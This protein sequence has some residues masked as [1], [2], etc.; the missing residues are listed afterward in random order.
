MS[1]FKVTTANSETNSHNVCLNDAVL[2]LIEKALAVSRT[3]I[4]NTFQ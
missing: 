4:L 2:D 3:Q 1:S